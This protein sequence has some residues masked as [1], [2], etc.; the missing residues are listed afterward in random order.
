MVK[1]YMDLYFAV[2][3]K[4]Q[5]TLENAICKGTNCGASCVKKDE[6]LLIGS[7]VEGVDGDGTEYHQLN[8]PFEMPTFW[9]TVQAVEDEAKE[10]WDATHGCDD[11][12]ENPD[13]GYH[14]IDPNCESCK[15]EGVVI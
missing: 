3:V 10:I 8:F 13:T 4:T 1:T 7:I 15:G 9:D 5:A 14:F 12:P 11:C 2:G 6:G